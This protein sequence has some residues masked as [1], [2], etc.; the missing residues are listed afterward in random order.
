MLELVE[1]FESKALFLYIK[2]RSHFC[3]EAIIV[4]DLNLR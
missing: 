3:P 2:L 1:I 4:K